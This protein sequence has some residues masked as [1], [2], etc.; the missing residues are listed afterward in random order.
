[1]LTW[2]L[3]STWKE[4]YIPN[5]TDIIKDKVTEWN[6]LETSKASRKQA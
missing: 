5:K 6:V 3:T 2:Y 4:G 1:M